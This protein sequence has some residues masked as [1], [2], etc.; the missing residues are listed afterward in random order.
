MSKKAKQLVSN[1]YKR[2]YDGIDNVCVVDLTGLDAIRNH[3]LRGALRQ[4][5][6]RLHVVR[7]SLFRRA[8]TAGP[9][10]S[11]AKALTG[12]C[13]LVTGGES[14]VDVAKELVRISGE[15]EAL[16]LRFGVMDGE[17]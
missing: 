4:K 10:A 2:W 15:I 8:F 12:P 14:L 1:E 13:A 5:N 3:K 7:N 6:I 9:M 11:V 17:P 16:K